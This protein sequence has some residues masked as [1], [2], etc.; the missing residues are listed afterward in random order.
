MSYAAGE[1]LILT[2]IQACTGFDVNNAVRGIY[3]ILNKGAA[4]S[5]AIIR[6]STFTHTQ[7]ALGGMGKTVQYTTEWVTVCELF[8]HLRDYGTSLA[9]LAARRQ[10]IINRFNA[11]PRAADTTGTVEDVMVVSGSEIVEVASQGTPVFLKQDLMIQWRENTNVTL[12][13]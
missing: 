8:V 1:A 9:E 13:E 7:S 4:K 12:Q 5:Y 11:Y 10:E 2:Q 3:T 6:P